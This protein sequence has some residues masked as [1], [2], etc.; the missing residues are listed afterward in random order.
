VFAVLAVLG[1]S[2]WV[3]CDWLLRSAAD[4]WIV[5]DPIGPADAVAVFGGGLADRS[6]AAAEY[7]RRGLV[8]KILIDI[9]ESEAAL[10]E[11]GIPGSAIETFGSGLKNTYQEVLVLRAWTQSHHLR[12]IIVPTEIFSTR[13]VSWMLHRAF[14]NEFAIRVIALDAP[15]YQRNNWWHARGVGAFK[16]EFIKYVYYLARY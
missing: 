12:S 10:L 8:K 5:S 7:Y 16:L 1:T 15:G 9:P 2:A 14:P 3:G 11:L 13:R 6:F 4:I